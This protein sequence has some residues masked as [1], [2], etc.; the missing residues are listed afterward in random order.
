MTKKSTREKLEREISWFLF[1]LAVFAIL[2]LTVLSKNTDLIQENL[3]LKEQ[4]WT[5]EYNQL[6]NS[7]DGIV[8]VKCYDEHGLHIWDY[9]IEY[10]PL[11]V[12]F[13]YRGGNCEVLP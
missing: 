1:L 7:S 4:Y 3:A 6:L 2:F 13:Y 9:Y 12:Y 10:F 11:N 8:I 5:S